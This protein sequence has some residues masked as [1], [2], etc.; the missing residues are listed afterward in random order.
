MVLGICASTQLESLLTCE[1]S[2][3]DLIQATVNIA[4]FFTGLTLVPIHFSV[5]GGALKGLEESE[6]KRI[7][8]PIGMKIIPRE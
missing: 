5:A 3:T 6:N 4:I 8:C 7:Q 2:L 1:M